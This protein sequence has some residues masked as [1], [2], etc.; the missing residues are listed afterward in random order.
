MVN[1]AVIS[2]PLTGMSNYQG[3]TKSTNYSFM[4][5]FLFPGAQQMITLQL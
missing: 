3:W 1:P 5:Q 4:P 2:D